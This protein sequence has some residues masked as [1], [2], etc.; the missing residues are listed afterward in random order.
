MILHLLRMR[1]N[2]NR[3]VFNDRKKTSAT[4]VWKSLFS[5]NAARG[6]IVT[7]VVENVC[8]NR[9]RSQVSGLR[10]FTPNSPNLG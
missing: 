3:N 2:V 7:S 9:Q 1:K 4:P 6:R 10:L 8:R 5:G